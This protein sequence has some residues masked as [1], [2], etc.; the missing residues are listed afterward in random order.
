MVALTVPM[1]TFHSK[2]L[3][4]KKIGFVREMKKKIMIQMIKT[5][6]SVLGGTTCQI[7]EGESRETTPTPLSISTNTDMM[8]THSGKLA[9]FI[10]WQTLRDKLIK[11]KFDACLAGKQGVTGAFNTIAVFRGQAPL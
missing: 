11:L 4:T 5:G 7:E 9:N 8:V 10:Y 3:L 6:K 1:K 2:M